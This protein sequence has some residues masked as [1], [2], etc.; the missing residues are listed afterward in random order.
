[1]YRKLMAED[2]ALL[3]AEILK[4][5]VHSKDSAFSL[6]IFT[7]PDTRSIVFEDSK[8]VVF[9]AN[10]C[11][12]MRITIQFCNGVEKERIRRIFE[13][14]I[15]EFATAFKKAGYIAFVYETK[16]KVLSWFLRRFGF[17]STEIQRKEL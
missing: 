16:S 5:E 14:H 7:N 13:Q 6:D 10:L 4:D 8:G 9:Y 1:M 15:P 2:Y 11:K 17:R 3:K 12:E